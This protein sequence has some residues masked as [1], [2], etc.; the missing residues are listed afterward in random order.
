MTADRSYFE[1]LSEKVL[2]NYNSDRNIPLEDFAE[3][4]LL[5][6]CYNSIVGYHDFSNKVIETPGL[7]PHAKILSS[8]LTAWLIAGETIHAAKKL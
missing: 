4:V 1:D 7:E 6:L 8:A 2:D 3:E 5:G